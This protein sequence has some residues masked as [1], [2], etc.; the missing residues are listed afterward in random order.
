[1]RFINKNIEIEHVSHV[2]QWSHEAGIWTGLEIIAGLPFENNEDICLTV[3][4][5]HAHRKY[6]DEVWLNE[7]FLSFGSDMVESPHKF[8][9][10]NIR[11]YYRLPKLLDVDLEC[12]RYAFD[13]IGGLSWHAKQ[14]QTNESY[15]TIG[16]ALDGYGLLPDYDIRDEMNALFYLYTC[17]SDKS[18]IK[19]YLKQYQKLSLT[20]KVYSPDR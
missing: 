17:L 3:D 16:E 15:Q 13:E 20:E 4:F 18:K 5:I 1:M 7:F 8:G 10:K 6:L 11:D 19:D 12:F 9:I 14:R 2:L